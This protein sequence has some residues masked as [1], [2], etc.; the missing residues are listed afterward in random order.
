MAH[1]KLQWRVICI[2]ED[3]ALK[4][5][6]ED[7]RFFG[8]AQAATDVDDDAWL[9]SMGQ[10]R[11]PSIFS[12]MQR[13]PSPSTWFAA[14]SA[15]IDK[16]VMIAN[17]PAFES[18]KNKRVGPDG[19]QSPVSLVRTRGHPSP[20]QAKADMDSFEHYQKTQSTVK[21]KRDLEIS[22]TTNGESQVNV[23]QERFDEEQ[24]QE[25]A[26]FSI[27]GSP[28]RD[29]DQSHIS[30]TV[31]QPA[32]HESLLGESFQSTNSQPQ[33]PL[34]VQTWKHQDLRSDDN[35]EFTTPGRSKLKSK[36]LQ[37][38]QHKFPNKPQPLLD[39][40]NLLFPDVIK[41]PIR[42]ECGMGLADL[43]QIP[44]Q[45]LSKRRVVLR[46]VLRTTD[47]SVRTSIFIKPR[48][49]V[50]EPM[51]VNSVVIVFKP[52]TDTGTS[53]SRVDLVEDASDSCQTI[54]LITSTLRSLWVEPDRPII[55]LGGAT[56]GSQVSSRVRLENKTDQTLD[57]CAFLEAAPEGSTSETQEWGE[58]ACPSEE[59][60]ETFSIQQSSRSRDMDNSHDTSIQQQFHDDI[61]CRSNKLGWFCLQAHES[62]YVTVI[63]SP[64]RIMRHNSFLKVCSKISLSAEPSQERSMLINSIQIPVMGYGGR[65]QVSCEGKSSD[66]DILQVEGTRS[67]QGSWTLTEIALRNYG[68]RTAYVRA[69]PPQEIQGRVLVEPQSC[70]LQPGEQV[71]LQ[72][73]VLSS[74]FETF[75]PNVDAVRV[76]WGDEILR[77]LRTQAK[78]RRGAIADVDLNETMTSVSRLDEFDDPM[79]LHTALTALESPS[80][81]N[82]ESPV[83]SSV[84]LRKRGQS[85]AAAGL[86]HFFDEYLFEQNRRCTSVEVCAPSTRLSISKEKAASRDRRKELAAIRE[87]GITSAHALQFKTYLS[88]APITV[89]GRVL[90]IEP[91]QVCLAYDVL[92]DGWSGSFE[93]RNSHPS[94]PMLASVHCPNAESLKPREGD[95]ENDD[96]GLD[97]QLHV[98]PRG[99]F[100]I[101]PG[102][103]V[104]VHLSCLCA[105]PKTKI[106]V[107]NNT[108]LGYYDE[109]IIKT[110]KKQPA[111]APVD[112][113][114]ALHSHLSK[115]IGNKIYENKFEEEVEKE[116]KRGDCVYLNP[117]DT[118]AF[119][120]TRPG[121]NT[122]CSVHICNPTNRTLNLRISTQTQT[123]H[124][125]SKHRC[126]QL[127]PHR[128][129]ILPIF[130]GPRQST[131]P[132]VA[133]ADRVTVYSAEDQHKAVLSVRGFTL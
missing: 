93:V 129:V 108:V 85:N 110:A 12:P 11:R 130:F 14:R 84:L 16:E 95:D 106:Y 20:S 42:L 61:S 57:V 125:R 30:S 121:Q 80:G 105:I 67:P 98:A 88:D 17:W 107:C 6:E 35:L 94:E 47:D 86:A 111:S 40:P 55:N 25:S 50:I 10:G 48:D 71:I 56:P 44:I 115:T 120:A 96:S 64:K 72:C 119:P 23:E 9:V 43:F 19:K 53:W 28:Q 90:L 82:K 22:S 33:K 65:A 18:P 109:I 83:S 73:K 29:M 8:G 54:K 87:E 118:L 41:E 51:G 4:M 79:A 97:Q 75:G 123:F 37:H 21:A 128:Y 49:C 34:H 113:D 132:G 92:S 91:R 78:S 122:V 74:L 112:A 59:A 60:V 32:N 124:V 63:F 100:S 117:S 89:K 45:N 36:S 103:C 69:N 38:L 52:R 5:I 68:E 46:P 101:A 1:F 15:P 104:R 131:A 99:V 116:A 7:A 66:V 58:P 70:T 2:N 13:P 81:V 39:P 31:S 26:N 24:E 62:I 76:E 127:K 114:T 133:C 77:R 3:D 126:I 102:H 27:K